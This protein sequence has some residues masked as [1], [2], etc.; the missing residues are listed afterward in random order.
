M[1]VKQQGRIEAESFGV[2]RR[3]S[4]IGKP[5][6]VLINGGSASAAEIVSGALRD[7][8]GVT[9][10]GERSFG[11]GTVQNI[12]SLPHGTSMH[13]TTSQWLLPEGDS[14]QETGLTPDVVATDSAETAVDEQ[15]QAAIKQVGK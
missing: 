1:I 12:I 8:L 6:S 11:K 7:R 15:L 5:L 3:G 9:L 10:V 14:I 13:V 2:N 4:L